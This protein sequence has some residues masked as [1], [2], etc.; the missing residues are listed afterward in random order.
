MKH[1]HVLTVLLMGAVGLH[2]CKRSFSDEIVVATSSDPPP[3]AA[4][5]DPSNIHVDDAIAELCDIPTP[6]FSF[7]SAK[8]TKQAKSSLQVLAECFISGRAKGKRLALVGHTDPR[9]EDDYNLALGDRRA[10]SVAKQL[11]KNGLSDDRIDVTSRGEM[12]ASGTDEA[13]WSNDRRVDIR[14]ASN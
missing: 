8:L 5:D 1:S 11:L 4:T 14:L 2:A 10:G 7:D 3:I 12:E 13:G 9:G 6:N